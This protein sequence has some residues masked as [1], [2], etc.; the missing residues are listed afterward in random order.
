[1]NKNGKKSWKFLKR[2]RPTK[3]ALLPGKPGLSGQKDNEDYL[4][5]DKKAGTVQ[6]ISWLVRIARPVLKPLYLSGV[7]VYKRQ[8]RKWQV[9]SL[10][11]P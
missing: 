2:L 4:V 3:A 1:M 11:K 5:A 7:D 10:A 8:V 6:L 9:G